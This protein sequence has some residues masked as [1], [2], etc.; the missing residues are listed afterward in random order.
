ML[1]IIRGDD[2]Y[3][4]FTFTDVDGLAI[5]LSDSD[6]FFTVKKYS[7][8]LDDDAYIQKDFAFVGDG[9]DGILEVYLANDETDI[10]EGVYSYDVQV[11]N[12]QGYIFSSSSGKLKVNRDIT[13]RSDTEVSA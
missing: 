6:I 3:L 5:D 1:Q 4:E 7:S 11:K 9:G 8:D 2:S 13:L 12:D 10:E